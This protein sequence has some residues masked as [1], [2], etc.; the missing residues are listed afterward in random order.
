MH[1]M[2]GMVFNATHARLLILLFLSLLFLLGTNTASAN[3]FRAGTMS[4]SA[5]NGNTISLNAG[6]GWTHSHGHIPDDAEVGDVVEGAISIDFGDGHLHDGA[7]RVTSRNITSDDV[8]TELVSIKP[9]DSVYTTGVLHTYENPGDYVAYWGSSAREGA[10]NLDGDAWRNETLINIGG[11]YGGNSSP[12]TAVSSVVQVPDNQV[13][14]FQLVGVDSNGDDIRFRYGTQEE[15]FDNGIETAAT[16]PTGLILDEDG[17][18]T[19][20]VTDE[21]LATNI[22]DRWQMT[23]MVEDLDEE[24]N[25]KS[26]VPLDFVLLISDS[27]DTP[28]TLTASDDEHAI[29][30]DETLEFTLTAVDPDWEGGDASPVISVVNP[31][32]A[33]SDVWSTSQDSTDGTTTMEVTFTPS[34]NERGDDFVVIFQATDAAGN[35]SIEVVTISTRGRDEIALIK[36]QDYA[37]DQSNPAP[38]IDDYIDAG[39]TDVTPENLAV[40]NEIIAD[41]GQSAVESISEVQALVDIHV[42]AFELIVEY[43]STQGTSTAPT[44]EDYAHAGIDGVTAQ[45]LSVINEAIATGAADIDDIASLQAFVDQT[46]EELSNTSTG[47][48]GNGVNKSLRN[49]DHNTDTDDEPVADESAQED[50][51][52]EEE[53]ID[54]ASLSTEEKR[55]LVQELTKKVEDLMKELRSLQGGS[56]SDGQVTTVRDLTVGM[57]G[58]DVRA[59]QMLLIA[60]DT[61]PAAAELLRVT[62]TGY[63]SNYTKNALSEYQLKYGISPSVGY[64]GSITRAQ[65][66]Q[67]GLSG[68]WW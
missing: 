21:V 65:M 39:I 19:W 29:D 58:E 48:G 14:E 4:W 28:P 62:A 61:G 6:V 40:I 53:P 54:I 42:D 26:Y 13:F 20:D 35:V 37:A 5:V 15:F 12:I 34:I 66:K 57:E 33:D 3:H 52:D 41:G 18:V 16:P 64:F 9:G 36:I 30:E 51:A 17:S 38:T 23:V 59:L 44:V 22:G 8:Q 60:Q 67:A 31:P 47:G 50:E 7:M 49:T 32:S 56:A 63:F 27:S 1:S 11:T 55:A 2:K 43:A 45:N 10:I 24:G 68:L 25:V 46:I